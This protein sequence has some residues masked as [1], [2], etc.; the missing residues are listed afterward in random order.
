MKKKVIL[1]FDNT[2]GVR[3]SDVDD[4]LTFAYLYMHEDIDLQAVTCTFANNA[5]HVVYCNTL[6]MWEDLGIDDVPVYKGGRY[7]ESYDSP[8]VD[9]LVKAV[10]EAPG[11]ITILA[12]GSLCNIA[13][14][15]TKD[16]EF[17]NKI[18][19]LIIMGGITEP[20]YLNGSLL[21]ELN[22][23]VDYKSAAKVI[24]NCPNLSI[25]SAQCTQDA[26]YKL[27]DLEEMIQMDTEFMRWS[28]PILSNWIKSINAAYGNRKVF[29]NWDL[30]TAIYLTNP[31]LFSTSE[32]R[33]CKIED[34]MKTGWMQ[35]DEDGS[36]DDGKVN[37]VDMPDKIIN[38]EKFN[39]LFYEM[40]SKMK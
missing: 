29:I 31:E 19:R 37:V 16:P 26:I 17:F 15:Y 3:K 12:I 9:Y 33:I 21:N 27:D 1:D 24:Y 18:E 28:K 36:V 10:N 22:F 23:S 32:K 6:Q 5:L 11:E 20:L 8:A 39:E 2:M 34:N 40:I 38:I 7:P 30:C 25:L 13:G 14:A 35:I 4:G